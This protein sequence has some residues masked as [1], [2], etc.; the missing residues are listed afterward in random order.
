[1]SPQLK[2]I[3]PLI[4]LC[5]FLSGSGGYFFVFKIKQYVNSCNIRF[6][7]NKNLKNNL[8]EELV[9]NSGDIRSLKWI[10]KQKEF[11]YRGQMFD[12]VKITATGKQ[13]HYY[14]I[15]DAKEKKL[16]SEFRKRS[17]SSGQSNKIIRK[18]TQ[19]HFIISSLPSKT[20]RHMYACCYG[21]PACLYFSP[22]CST[23]SP[24]PKKT[25]IS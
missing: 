14:C 10:K 16:I 11:I 21:Q 3:I 7:I 17:R 22:F 23:S 19:S 6:E 13:L 25:S 8:R 24:P 9:F 15:K 2:K 1:M 12:V 18:L 4:V 20:F 5:I